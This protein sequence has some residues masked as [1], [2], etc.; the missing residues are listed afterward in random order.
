MTTI[1]E[2]LDK[3]SE[4]NRTIRIANLEAAKAPKIIIEAEEKKIG[5]GAAHIGKIKEFG[6]LTF[7]EV[8]Q[9]KGLKGKPY[10]RFKNDSGADILLVIGKWGPYLYRQNQKARPNGK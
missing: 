7:I 2:Y 3:K 5:T 4:E 8:S 10:L 1:R 6:P 9:H